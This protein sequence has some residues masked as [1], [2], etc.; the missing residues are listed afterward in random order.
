MSHYAKCRKAVQRFL[1]N[2]RI[3]AIGHIS[4]VDRRSGS[5]ASSGEGGLPKS[6]AVASAAQLTDIC[7]LLG[8]SPASITARMSGNDRMSFLQAFLE[9][10]EQIGV[11][12]FATIGDGPTEH[13]LWIEGSKGS[14]RTD[15][16]SV[17]WRKRGWPVFIPTRVGLFGA[18]SGRKKPLAEDDKLTSALVQS[19]SGEGTVR[20]DARE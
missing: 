8:K 2:D 18:Y 19:A 14:L 15:G 12:Y 13:E 17:W 6:L 20:M 3:G 1:K 5:A 10:S 11:Q 7:A 16:N 4:C 9:I